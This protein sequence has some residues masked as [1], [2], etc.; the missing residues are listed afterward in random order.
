MSNGQTTTTEKR[1]SISGGGRLQPWRTPKSRRNADSKTDV[2]R[3]TQQTTLRLT[4][5]NRYTI[6]ANKMTEK[7]IS[8]RRTGTIDDNRPT[9]YT[10]TTSVDC[11]KKNVTDIGLH[12][13]Q[14]TNSKTNFHT[15]ACISNI[16]RPVKIQIVSP[17][18]QLDK[19]HKKFIRTLTL[20]KLQK[21][22]TIVDRSG[23]ECHVRKQ[24]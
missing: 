15:S 4:V 22:R 3:L 18:L 9:N 19:K 16:K 13:I 17:T 23:P 20:W 12:P 1:R 7:D 21:P 11:T 2:H 6:L 8:L 14:D 24:I 10:Q 5:R